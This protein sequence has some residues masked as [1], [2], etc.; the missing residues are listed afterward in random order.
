MPE[1][2][3]LAF[4]SLI[5]LEQ[6]PP[7]FAPGDAN[8]WT[9]P[10]IAR[11]LLAVHLDPDSDAASRRPEIIDLSA[12]WLVHALGWKEGSSVLDLGCGPG[13]YAARLAQHGLRVT[14]VDFS[15]HS[16]DY[17]VELARQNNLEIT[18]RC[19]DYLDLAESSCFDAALL[20]YGDLCPLSPQQRIR[21]LG[22]VHRALKPGGHFVL[23]VST[24]QLRR[25][26]GLKNGWYAAQQGFWRPT[27]HLVLEQG[28]AYE[29]NVFLDQFL[30]I[31]ETGKITV[32]RNWFQD[33]S[34]ETISAELCANGFLVE[35]LWNDLAGTP[36]DAEGDWIGIIARRE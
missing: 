36:I 32:Y 7:L 2:S 26:E 34:P 31:E 17:A 25:R 24:P 28:F 13:L 10:H 35:N 8:F 27:P 11:Q 19:E 6:K 20:I 15:Q 14:G 1:S 16:I 21:L 22:N 29:G 3:L 9:E 12:D 33:Y 4:H 23:D 30:V 18:Y 5:A